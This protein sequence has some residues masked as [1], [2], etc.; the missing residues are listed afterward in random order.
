MAF[1][2]APDE[3]PNQRMINRAEV[4]FSP[5]FPAMG[6]GDYAVVEDTS[7]AERPIVACACLWR[8]RWSLGGIPLAVGRPE[9]VAT[10][11][12]YRN[13][14]LVRS[15]FEMLHARSAARGDDIQVI[16][17][18][19]FYYRQFGYEYGLELWGLRT[20]ELEAI[21]A[22][23]EGADEPYTLRPA[24]VGDVAE[25]AALYNQTRSRSL[26]WSEIGEEEWRYYITAP[27]EPHLRRQDPSTAGLARRVYVAVAKDG[28]VC[29]FTL[30]HS[31]RDETF[32]VYWLALR[33]E[34]N[35]QGAMPSLLRGLRDVAQQAPAAKEG[36]P[37]PRSISL[38]LGT[39]HPAYTV[40]GNKLAPYREEP[41]GWYVRVGDIPAFVRRLAPVLE[42]RLGESVLNGHT[43]ELVVNFYRGGLRLRFAEGKLLEVA[44]W[45]APDYG[46]DAQAGCPE[47]VF[48]Q[49]LFGHRSLAE[50]REIYPDVWAEEPA[51]VLIDV[52]L[53]KQSST[54]LAFGYT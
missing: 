10:E 53:P 52:L 40:L 31:R 15:L 49:L 3:P 43:G 54:V 36:I 42:R 25:I 47:T 39:V 4:M 7:R 12:E 27:E 22:L 14:G 16:F 51:A 8:Q 45:R 50:L 6:P 29:G 30:V 38:V 26:A 13:R 18:I 19:P 23:K 28:H 37:A 2:H 48:T 24:A 9:Y 1:R 20:V 34:V 44:S 33:P 21:P 5:G 35:W 41:Y 46:D 32:H 11:A 17:G